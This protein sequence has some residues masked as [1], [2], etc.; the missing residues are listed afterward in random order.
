MYFKLE[1]SKFWL[2][3]KFD[4]NAISG[5]CTRTQLIQVLSGW[6]SHSTVLYVHVTTYPC[7]SGSCPWWSCWTCPPPTSC[8]WHWRSYWQS[9]NLRSTLSLTRPRTLTP[10]SRSVCWWK[11][12]NVLARTTQYVWFFFSVSQ[13][14]LSQWE[15]MLHMSSPVKPEAGFLNPT[16]SNQL[17]HVNDSPY[18]REYYGEFEHLN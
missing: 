16:N 17:W 18:Y 12:G 2:N 3:F 10:K 14:D 15:K 11:P 13:Q 8:G 4:R 5:T 9:L 6:V 7:F 1:H